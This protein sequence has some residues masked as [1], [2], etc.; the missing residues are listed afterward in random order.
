MKKTEIY[1]P[2]GI[3]YQTQ[4]SF[5]EVM[6]L[7][8]GPASRPDDFVYLTLT[9]GCRGAF[10]PREVVGVNEYEDTEHKM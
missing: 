9:D 1:L 5:A 3:A 2:G 8:E 6:A 7:V 10:R 4:T